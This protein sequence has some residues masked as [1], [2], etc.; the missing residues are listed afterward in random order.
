M[1]VARSVLAAPLMA[2]LVC[3]ATWGCADRAAGETELTMEDLDKPDRPE[4]EPGE[5]SS[6]LY[7]A[8]ESVADCGGL[9]YCLRP[10]GELGFCTQGCSAGAPETCSAGADL[11]HLCRAVDGE[12]I[13]VLDC[14]DAP[15]PLGMKCKRVEVDGDAESLC[16]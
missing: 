1:P 15:C 4:G 9:D 11:D 7:A 14:S 16:F 8:C 3:G 10:Q 13:C 6:Y 5:G 2:L 12:Q